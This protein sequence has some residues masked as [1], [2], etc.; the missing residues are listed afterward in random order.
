MQISLVITVLNEIKTIRC[1]LAGIEKFS[2]FPSEI[3]FVD[4][5]SEDGTYELLHDWQQRVQQLASFKN[6]KLRVLQKKGNISVGRNEGIQKTAH[7]WIAITDAGCIPKPD[8]IFQLAAP[9]RTRFQPSAQQADQQADQKIDQKTDQQADQ[10]ADQKTDQKIDQKADQMTLQ[11]FADTLPIVA[12]FYSGNPKSPFEHAV[13][14][15]VLVP[16]EKVDPS[17]FLPATRSM[18]LHKKTWRKLGKFREDLRVSEDYFFAQQA[19]AQSIPIIFA[20]K[21]IV[22]WRPRSNIFS[23][24]KMVYLHAYY[25]QLAGIRRPKVTFIFARYAVAILL[26]VAAYFLTTQT[27]TIL[28]IC[29]GVVLY[30]IWAILKHR[31]HLPRQGVYYLPVLQWT[32]DVAVMLGTSISLHQ[33]SKRLVK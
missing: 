15:F 25:D 3:I 1:L 24:C 31:Q 30:S 11:K 6:T 8:W 16:P 5:G 9:V 14:P 20:P 10:K 28:V 33:S 19:V 2:E 32:S 26:V 7:D 4:G 12:G 18:L 27:T 22:L 17:T 21:A 13:V 29:T 23:F